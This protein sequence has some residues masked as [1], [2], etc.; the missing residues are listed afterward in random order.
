MLQ[1]VSV[2]GRDIDYYLSIDSRD[3]N[4]DIYPS[5]SR[6]EVQLNPSSTFT[7][8]TIQRALKN[9]SSIEVIDVM[10]PNTNN[11]LNEMFLYLCIPEIDGIIEA[12]GGVTNQAFAKLIP[13]T[14]IGSHVVCR[15]D[16]I[17]RPKKVFVSKGARLDKLTIEFRRYDGTLFD[18]G[19]DFDSSLAP[20]PAVQTSV[21]L[22]AS[23]GLPYLT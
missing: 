13:T 17:D 4:R 3:R 2:N 15:F 1:S 18:F 12:T 16:A 10:I 21:T 8:A 6:F 22:K 9:V 23:I 11:V 5:S 14:V 7:G 19:D 20:K